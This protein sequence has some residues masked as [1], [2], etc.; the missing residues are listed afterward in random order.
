MKEKGGEVCINRFSVNPSSLTHC[1]AVGGAGPAPR[2]MSL[3]CRRRRQTRPG[4]LEGEN[5]LYP[6][7]LCEGSPPDYHTNFNPRPHTGATGFTNRV[8]VIDEISIHAPIRGRLSDG[9]A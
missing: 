5:L 8:A 4:R 7:T 9:P 3:Q 2:Q 6:S 1:D